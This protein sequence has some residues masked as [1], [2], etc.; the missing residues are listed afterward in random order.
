ML[1]SSIVVRRLSSG[2]WSTELSA[3]H[4]AV[5]VADE[6]SNGNAKWPPSSSLVDIRPNAYV[7]A[8]GATPPWSIGTTVA[9]LQ[10]RGQ[11][12]RCRDF[13]AA[14]TVVVLTWCVVPR[15][16]STNGTHPKRPAKQVMA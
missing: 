6:N 5:T 16:L 10:I 11:H 8:I 9:R 2:S 7:G 3:S 12:R 13:L 4:R 15:N 14:D 1:P